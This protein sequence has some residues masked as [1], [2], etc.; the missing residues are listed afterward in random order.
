VSR[1]RQDTIDATC[2]EVPGQG[3][4][5]PPATALDADDGSADDG[6]ADDGSA[7]DGSADDGSADDGTSASDDATP[8]DATPDDVASDDV[9]PGTGPEVLLVAVP[10]PVQPARSSAGTTAAITKSRRPITATAASVPARES[11]GTPGRHTPGVLLPKNVLDG[12]EA[13][14]VDLAFRRWDAPRVKVGGL[15]LTR[16]G[17]VA[18]DKVTVVRDPAKLTDREASRAGFPTA[19][20]LRKVLDRNGS[21]G[22]VYRVVLR[23]A[24]PDPRWSLREELPGEADV[25]KLRTRL[26]RLDAASPTGPWTRQVLRWIRD[27]PAV[28][29]TELAAA[30]D[31][32][33]WPLKVDIRK[34]KALG[35]T[36]SLTTGYELS[37]RGAA[38]LTATEGFVP[39]PEAG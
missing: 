3:T 8:D 6:S 1:C 15:Q 25:E 16:I 4:G 12:I 10:P 37:P 30:L 23:L 19:D 14:T 5:E 26:D 29:S 13:G 11:R 38:F 2:A 31:R 36:I 39:A 17:Q 20:A 21:D 27:H 34:L 9:V 32:D 22:Q 7:D 33:R 24:G 18:F 28:V 35:L